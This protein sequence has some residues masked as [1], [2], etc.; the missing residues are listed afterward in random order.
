LTIVSVILRRAGACPRA[1][2]TKPRDL[3]RCHPEEERRGISV[4]KCHPE[5][6]RR[7]ISLLTRDP[8]QARD[9]IYPA[10]IPR[11]AQDDI[12]PAEIPRFAQDDIYP[13]RDPSLRSGFQ[14]DNVPLSSSHSRST[15]GA[16]V[17]QSNPRRARS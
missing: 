9:D 5:E 16:M 8:S 2:R 12:Y 6:A 7:G 3:S 1:K 15:T 14:D 10:E 11:F 17:S 13:G 4:P